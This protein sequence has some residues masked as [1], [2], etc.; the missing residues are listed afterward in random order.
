MK[1]LQTRS[2]LRSFRMTVLILGLILFS[3]L[4]AYAESVYDRVMKKGEIRC[5]YFVEAPFTFRDEATGEFSG[6]AVDLAEL[7]A[8]D[9]NLKLKWQ[10]QISFASFGLDLNQK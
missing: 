4:P 1:I 9:L 6:I 7:I 3:A 5:G 2:S 8:K 10:E